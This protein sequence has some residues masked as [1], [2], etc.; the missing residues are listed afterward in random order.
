LAGGVDDSP[1]E[2]SASPGVP[3]ALT[4][5]FVEDDFYHRTS[6]PVALASTM[7][8]GL[9]ATTGPARHDGPMM[10]IGVTSAVPS[11]NEV[12][13]EAATPVQ[14]AQED[15]LLP[16]EARAWSPTLEAVWTSASTGMPK[17]TKE[18]VV[19]VPDQPQAIVCPSSLVPSFP[20]VYSRRHRPTQ[21]EDSLGDGAVPAAQ[22]AQANTSP[23]RQTPSSSNR[24]SPSN[25]RERFMAKLTKKTAKILPTPRACRG[26]T[27]ARTPSAPPRRSRRIAGAD[28]ELQ[29]TV[30]PTRARKKVMRALNIIGENEGID[31]ETLKEYGELFTRSSTLV[32]SHVQAMAALFGWATPDEDMGAAAEVEDEC[33]W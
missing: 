3:A 8:L 24:S 25:K 27:R 19:P 11:L 20:K 1:V 21:V 28:P 10:K 16:A 7:G 12:E 13:L 15:D 23:Q 17:A 2:P 5:P 31:E 18:G 29:A 30:A 4:L 33:G 9:P 6:G 26:R 22:V 14:D 32:P